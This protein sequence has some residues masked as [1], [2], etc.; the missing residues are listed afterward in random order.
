MKKTITIRIVNYELYR[1]RSD[2][3]QH[4]W[5]RCSNRILEDPDFFDFSHAEII[6][7]IYI[8]G[9]SSQKGSDQVTLNFDHAERVCRIKKRVLSSALS[10]LNGKQI[11]YVDDTDALRER[12]DDD[13]DPAAREQNRTERREQNRTEQKTVAPAGADG[14]VASYLSGDDF[15]SPFLGKVPIEVQNAWLGTYAEDSEWIKLQIREAVTWIHGNPSKAPRSNFAKFF[16]GWLGRNWEWKRKNNPRGSSK[17][18]R[19]ED[20]IGVKNEN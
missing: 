17:Q 6:A 19:I 18:F 5:F 15:I 7:W 8:L 13:R 14:D 9:L 12:N 2:V 4:S 10:K 11:T 20:H 3:K 1:G 16:S